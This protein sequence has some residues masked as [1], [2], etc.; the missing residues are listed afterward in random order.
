MLIK[1]EIEVVVA[2]EGDKG[3]L[4]VIKTSIAPLL[5]FCF[6]PFV[7]PTLACAQIVI[8]R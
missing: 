6:F 7:P 1:K 8:Y 2:E 5:F 4:L 3:V